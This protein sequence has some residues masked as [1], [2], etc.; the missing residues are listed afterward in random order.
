MRSPIFMEAKADNAERVLVLRLD[1]W[2]RT[3]AL[4]LYYLAILLT[5][6]LIYGRGDFAPTKFIYQGF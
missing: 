3:V 4:F 2:P 6:L 1:G 5:L